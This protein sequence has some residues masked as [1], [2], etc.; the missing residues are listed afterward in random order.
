M[1]LLAVTA[2]M[3][4]VAALACWP[5]TG[6]MAQASSVQP[7][8]NKPVFVLGSKNFAEEDILGNLYQQALKAKGFMCDLTSSIGSTEAAYDA[9]KDGD[10]QGYPE[11][12]GTLLSTLAGI[13]T[14]PPS[15]TAGASESSAWL[16][17]RG[18]MFTS[19]TPFTD[20]NAIAVLKSF[21]HKHDLR[22]LADLAKLGKSLTLGAT[23][24]FQT[25]TPDGLS[26]LRKDYA[27]NLTFHPVKSGSFY[28]LLDNGK[29]GAAEVFSTDP[30]L[31]SGKY[32]VLQDPKGFFGFENVGLVL[33]KR[34]VE[35]EGSGFLKIVNRLS[36]LLTQRVIIRLNADVELDQRSPV[37][38]ARTFL[39]DNH[40][41]S[42]H[43]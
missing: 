28:K 19:T 33:S 13:S 3:A 21:A 14:S 29:L 16:S 24:Q 37:A 34:A 23:P 9:L 27:L 32:V 26:G 10:I 2:A 35:D 25:R 8:G 1:V 22:T 12:D 4:V 17:K 41:L 30:Q 6:S 40:M 7:V 42:G 36:A 39:K 31:Q 18:L 11:Y 43:S 38:V 5:G 15:A 20:S